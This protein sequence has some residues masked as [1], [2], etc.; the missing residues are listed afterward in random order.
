MCIRQMK[1]LCLVKRIVVKQAGARHR[2]VVVMG[3]IIWITRQC[4]LTSLSAMFIQN[5]I[6]PMMQWANCERSKWNFVSLVS[7]WMGTARQLTEVRFLLNQN[8]TPS[9]SCETSVFIDTSLASLPYDKTILV[10]SSCL[11]LAPFPAWSIPIGVFDHCL[12]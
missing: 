12:T 5:W 4:T 8:H 11:I 9:I 2:L 3:Y 7:A 1:C 6:N 10:R